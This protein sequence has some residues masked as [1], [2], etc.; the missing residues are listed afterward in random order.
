MMCG[1]GHDLRLFLAALWL[2]CASLELSM[3]LIIVALLAATGDHWLVC[4]RERNCSRRANQ[5]MNT[6][7]LSS[8]FCMQNMIL[9]VWQLKVAHFGVNAI[10]LF[11]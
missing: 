2:Y 9:I 3:Q 4:D 6:L 5:V 7:T 8:M 1:A 11:G 10:L